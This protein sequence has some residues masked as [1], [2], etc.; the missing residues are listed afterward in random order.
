MR[1][2]PESESWKVRPFRAGDECALVALFERVFGRAISEEQWRWKLK[3]R[4]CPAENVWLAIEGERIVFQYAGM[5]MRVKIDDQIVD[6]VVSVD[7]MVAPENQKQRLVTQIAPFT[8]ETW[9][10]GGIEFVFGTPNE[11]WGSMLAKLGF[12][13]LFPLERLVRPIRPEAL[14][15]R[16]LR[17]PFL[18]RL[19]VGRIPAAF[20]NR[21]LQRGEITTREVSSAGAE[22]DRLWENV[23]RSYPFAVVRD[24]SFVSWRFFEAPLNP[25][26]LL[27]AE[28]GGEPAGYAA[29]R[30]H[31]ADGRK[32]GTLA[33]IFVAKD[34]TAAAAA[35]LLDLLAILHASGVEKLLT[36]AVPGHFLHR[37]FRSSGF[38]AGRGRWS[39]VLSPFRPELP[40]ERL[41]NAESWFYAGGD[42]DNV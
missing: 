11:R 23:S 39:V 29:F 42:T 2:P 8:Y 17:F 28:R 3:R 40:M 1:A 6:A 7:T 33:E 38:L 30:I 20:W 21:K 18:S 32:D 15:A 25:C 41:K 26:R 22:F 14:L 35:L 27:L 13:T 10:E 16:R 37:F 19:P 24:R 5:P 12:E 36:L 4:F 9:R 31:E 34:D